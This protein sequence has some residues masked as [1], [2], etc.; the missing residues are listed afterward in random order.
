VNIV[1]AVAS[2]LKYSATWSPFF[3]FFKHYWRNCP[4]RVHLVTDGW[5]HEHKFWSTELAPFSLFEVT[6]NWCGNLLAFAEYAKDR[7]EAVLLFQDDFW[8][9]APVNDYAIDRAKHLMLEHNA[10]CVR[11]YP[12]PGSDRDIMYR[13][14]PQFGV[15]EHGSPY[16]I[17]CQTGLWRA[18]YLAD[19]LK[20]CG[21]TTPADFEIGGT[22][23][24]ESRKDPVLAWKRAIEPYP[25][26]YI[27]SAVSR[28][29]WEPDAK[30][31]CDAHGFKVDWSQRKFVGE[32]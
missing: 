15:V 27:C 7:N 24:A 4:Y 17:S 8:L 29:R 6:E 13:Y 23:Y 21:G 25:V 16:R 26:S 9:N 19:V 14:D 28:N 32:E 22:M 31:M 2:C 30:I 1:V 3:Q 20:H 11:L 5:T 10:G 12:C 18:D